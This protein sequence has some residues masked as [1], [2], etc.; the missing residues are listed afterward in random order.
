MQVF[1]PCLGFFEIWEYY[2]LRMG[3]WFCNFEIWSN[4]SS[5]IDGDTD[6]DD[7]VLNAGDFW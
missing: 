2:D 4:N 1:H 3:T 5:S 7:E 6:Y